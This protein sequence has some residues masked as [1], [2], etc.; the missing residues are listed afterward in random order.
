MLGEGAC[1]PAHLVG[2]QV[3]TGGIVGVAERQ[4]TGAFADGV[5]QR[6]RIRAAGRE[7]HRHGPGPRAGGHER[8]ERIRGPGRD[9]LLAW[10]EKRERGR[11]EQLGGAVAHHDLFCLHAVPFGQL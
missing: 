3:G 9:E 1:Q 7:V 4:H 6:T 10:G 8:V 2:R 5:E 11:L